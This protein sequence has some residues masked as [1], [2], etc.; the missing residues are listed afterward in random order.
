[1]AVVAVRAMEREDEVELLEAMF[2]EELSWPQPTNRYELEIALQLPAAGTATTLALALVAA[3][4][5][6]GYPM[7]TQ[8]SLRCAALGRAQHAALRAAMLAALDFSEP[9]VYAAVSWL[10]QEGAGEGEA[11]GALGAPEAALALGVEAAAAVEEAAAAAV[12]IGRRWIW[13]HHI[14]SPTK[15]KL[16]LRWDPCCN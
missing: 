9:V 7:S 13:F 3:L 10:Q 15:R 5:A 8:L 1:V 16:I 12:P 14:K 6:E 4:P 11:L 2:A